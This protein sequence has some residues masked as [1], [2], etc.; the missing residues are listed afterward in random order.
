MWSK[1]VLCRRGEP[2]VGV[3]EGENGGGGERSDGVQGEMEVYKGIEEGSTRRGR[4]M[5]S[6]ECRSVHEGRR[7]GVHEMES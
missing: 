3:R 7:N 2:L 5:K 1:Q 6:E 4:S